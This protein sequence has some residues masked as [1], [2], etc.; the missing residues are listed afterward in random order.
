MATRRTALLDAARA[1]TAAIAAAAVALCAA[2]GAGCVRPAAR[3]PHALWSADAASVD[4][5]FPDERLLDEAGHLALRPQYYAPFLPDGAQTHEAYALFDAYGEQLREVRGFGT[6]MPFYLRFSAPID[7]GSIEDAR[8]AVVRLDTGEPPIAA[9]AVW[10]ANPGYLLVKQALPMTGGGRYALVVT[11]GLT[12]GS[13]PI[14]RGADFDAWARAAGR[15]DVAAAALAIG[16]PAED[17]VAAAITVV[18]RATDDLVAAVARVADHVPTYDFAPD[19]LRLRGVWTKN[20][21]P[22]ELADES[23]VRDG[24]ASAGTIAIGAYASIDARGA[25]GR[26]DRAFLDGEAAGD[27]QRIELVLVEPDPARH[28]PPWP[29]VVVQHGFNGSNRFVLQVAKELNDQG[30][31]CIGLTAVQH[32]ERGAITSFFNL[33]DVR[34]ARDNFRQTVLDQVQL[35]SLAARG[36]IDVDGNPGADLDGTIMYFGHSM[37]AIIGSMFAAVAPRLDVSVVNAAGGGLGTIFQS[38]GL[39][40]MLGLLVR[41]ALGMDLQSEDYDDALPFY[42]GFSQ[43][44][45]AAG[46]PISYAPLTRA[47]HAAGAAYLLQKD[48]GDLLVPNE[49]T[50][51]LARALGLAHEDASAQLDAPGFVLWHLDPAELGFP[52][53]WDP[54]GVYFSVEGARLQAG[55]F[56]A[57]RG[58]TLLDPRDN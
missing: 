10:R 37:G 40:K 52:P 31:A 32:G 38:D 53:E 51:D 27:V 39:T 6:F 56:L 20:T 34:V 18:D 58:T 45:F 33:E 43:T 49:A 4:N 8:F 46:D 28:P 11:G 21:L 47:R 9:S 3:A 19:D 42:A 23:W 1:P 35:A 22:A 2:V 24:V 5:P 48:I 16:V 17:I 36:G 41:P 26:F 25:E 57:S 15:D 14:G 55:A 50:D 12:A 29:T 44:F 13:V 54:H 30:L 7:E